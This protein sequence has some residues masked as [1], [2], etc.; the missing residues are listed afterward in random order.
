MS[1]LAFRVKW[2]GHPT[3][4]RESLP[5]PCLRLSAFFVINQRMNV[6]DLLFYFSVNSL[7]MYMSTARSIKLE[8]QQPLAFKQA[9]TESFPT[10]SS[11]A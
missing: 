9:H 3:F 2:P 6:K 5:V 8:R 1:F 7:F 10:P 11:N 4:S